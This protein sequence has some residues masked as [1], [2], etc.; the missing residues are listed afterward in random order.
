MG[1]ALVLI[2]MVAIALAPFYGV[3]SRDGKRSL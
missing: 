2:L 3:D 1:I